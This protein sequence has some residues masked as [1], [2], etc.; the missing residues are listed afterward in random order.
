MRAAAGADRRARPVA[1]AGGGDGRGNR[2]AKI[3][4]LAADGWENTA[5]AD[6]L[7]VPV[8][9]VSTWRKRF[10]EEGLA[11]LKD[12]PRAGRPRASA[13][14]SPAPT[15]TGSSSASPPMSPPNWPRPRLID[16]TTYFQRGPLS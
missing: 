9:L 13:G 2:A 14:S 10:F 7:D 1:N 6:R 5:I 11:G 16:A 12:R 4:L 15:S 8:Q 3:V